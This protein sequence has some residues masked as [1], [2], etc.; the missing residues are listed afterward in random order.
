MRMRFAVAVALTVAMLTPTVCL[1]EPSSPAAD[2][3]RQPPAEGSAESEFNR[4]VR[5]RVAKDWSTAVAAFRD[6]INARAAFPEAWNELGY[7][8]RHQGRYVESLQAYDE[9]LRLRPNF[10]EALEYQRRPASP[11]APRRARRRAG[12]RARR[13]H[14]E[15]KV[16]PRTSTP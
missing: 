7:A 8:L 12:A 5:A 16:T 15:E 4:G 13:G 1:A 9:A 14:P 11:R 2:P 3:V 6:A 10:P